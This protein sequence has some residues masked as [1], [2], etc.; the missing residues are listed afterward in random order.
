MITVT[1][2]W[3]PW[4]GP[5]KVLMPTIEKLA[6][7]YNVPDSDVQIKKVN[8]DEDLEA[9]TKFGIRSIPTLVFEKDGVE[10]ERKSGIL[11]YAKI[12]ELI[13]NLNA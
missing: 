12:K 6:E 8:V 3:A 11:P 1:D 4:C 7:E 2:Y 10:V 9:S 13:E 5:C